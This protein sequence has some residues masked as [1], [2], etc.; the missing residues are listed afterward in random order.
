MSRGTGA[1]AVSS[2]VVADE[3]GSGA[4]SLKAFSIGVWS[5]VLRASTTDYS[6]VADDM[7]RDVRLA[8]AEAEAAA[9][10]RGLDGPRRPAFDERNVRRRVYDALNVLMACGVIVKE[11]VR[12]GALRERE[13]RV[14][15]SS[16]MVAAA[17]SARV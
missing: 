10:A 3:D 16:S 4:L 12:A 7:L 5:K 17:M 9:L 2:L 11:K 8:A 13:G 14:A 6:A 15:S 1:A